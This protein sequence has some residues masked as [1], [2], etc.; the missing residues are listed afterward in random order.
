MFDTL[1]IHVT[2]SFQ[3]FPESRSQDTII[4]PLSIVD[5]TVS[6]FARCAGIWFYNP[7]ADPRTTLSVSELEASLSKTLNSYRP[8]CGRLSYASGKGNADHTSRYRRVHVTYNNT[9][10]LG[11][12]LVSATS[13]RKLSDFVPS[14]DERKKKGSSWDLA[15]LPSGELLPIT[16]MALSSKRAADDAPNMIIQVTK[17][18]CGSTAVGIAITH[19]LSDAQSMC[20]FAKDW[21]SVNRALH[22]SSSMPT[23]SPVF[24]PQLLDGAAA[25]NIDVETPDSALVEAARKLPQHRFDWY[26]E[27]PGQPMPVH[28]PDDLNPLAVLSPS[29]PIPWWDWDVTLSEAGR[30]I[31]FT[32]AQI[33]YIFDQ[34]NQ[35]PTSKISK[36]DS[37]L[38]HMWSRINEARNLPTSTTTYLDLT[39]GLRPR[40]SLPSNF[41]GSPI[42][43]AAVPWTLSSSNPSLSALASSIRSILQ[44]FTPSSI[45]AI[46][47]D[48]AF[49][50]SPQ[51]LWRAFL[52]PKHI[53]QTTWVQSGFQDINFIGE[54]G[55]ELRYVQPEMGGDGLLLVME[56]LGSEKG[57]WTANG[58]DVHVFLE[59]ETMMRVRK[60][61][62]SI[63]ACT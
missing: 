43:I 42:M 27:V 33:R 61:L 47:H 55:P 14:P 50:V 54:G 10:D 4:T 32:P 30:V 39:I 1:D 3:V 19:G 35:D 41:L 9:R 59:K 28:T 58:V 20:T 51:R 46:L 60:L 8:W 7:P 45:G 24:N 36:H 38:A 62:F 15:Q 13:P 23:L 37:L 11:V 56:A 16:S 25:G 44:K 6:Y 34:A 63:V 5:S 29:E 22:S 18:A 57:H 48:A 2:S 21:A 53:L 12:T 49:E 40:L 52:G 17:F 26:K 31:H